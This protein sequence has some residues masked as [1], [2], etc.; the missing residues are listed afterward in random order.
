M[1]PTAKTGVAVLPFENLSGDNEN[2]YFVGGIHDDLLVNLS[3]IRDLKVI[4]RNSVMVYKNT[5]HKVRDI[6]N[7]L[8]V[9][10]V[11]EGSVRHK[12]NRARINVQLIDAT[13][14]AQIW[15]ENYDREMT[16]A[17]AL[18]SDLAFQIASAL[19]A[20][21]TARG[22]RSLETS[23]DRKWR[24]LPALHSSER[25]LRQVREAKA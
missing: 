23:S 6:G 20:K 7:T 19:K 14:E 12:G 18:Q 22:N 4:S 11:L 15:A 2:A 17:F 3:K 13:N 9:A 1:W 10:A 5:Q 21:L 16:D 25:S 8:G 24:S